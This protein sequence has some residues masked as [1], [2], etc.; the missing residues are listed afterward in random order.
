MPQER[1]FRRG[2]TISP[3][4]KGIAQGRADL[5]TRQLTL[6]FGALPAEAHTRIS[7]ASIAELDAIGER[8]L[9]ASTLDE[10]LQQR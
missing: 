4:P 10:A 9:T 6:R 1:G 5:L 7:A 8:L 3:H 2:T